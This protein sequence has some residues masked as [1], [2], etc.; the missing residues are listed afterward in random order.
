MLEAAVLTLCVLAG[1]PA[2]APEPSVA[3][4]TDADEARLDK[5]AH[6]LDGLFAAT[7]EEADGFDVLV[8][9][10]E[11]QLAAA[12]DAGSTRHAAIFQLGLARSWALW[13]NAQDDPARNE[14]A[15]TELDELIQG[16]EATADLD[17]FRRTVLADALELR[18][19]LSPPEPEPEPEPQP[20]PE[21][22]P[23]ARPDPEPPRERGDEPEPAEPSRRTLGWGLVAGGVGLGIAGVA[24][25]SVGAAGVAIAESTGR[26]PDRLDTEFWNE[27]LP[28]R[29]LAWLVSGSL[30]AAIGVGLGTT[31]AIIL[32]RH[33]K[34]RVS[35]RPSFGVGSAGL[36]LSGYF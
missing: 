15:L 4:P 13:A 34:Q 22:E 31:G 35:V 26:D 33:P 10:H 23:Q 27:T 32:K 5:A 17:L 14:R 28:N 9:M 25:I 30:T 12:R 29:R 20:K 7:E 1:A 3:E 16:L 18:D 36:H 8:S 2:L 11:K 24:M 19:S 6:L 21:P